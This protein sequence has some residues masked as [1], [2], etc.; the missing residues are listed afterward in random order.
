MENG[1]VSLFGEL[2]PKAIAGIISIPGN[3]Q[4]TAFYAFLKQQASQYLMFR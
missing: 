3:E 4:N 2:N 1:K